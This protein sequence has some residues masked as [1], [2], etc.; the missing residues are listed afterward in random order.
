MVVIPPLEMARPGPVVGLI[1]GQ[2]HPLNVE[3]AERRGGGQKDVKPLP[4]RFIRTSAGFRSHHGKIGRRGF[5]SFEIRPHQGRQFF[6]SRQGKLLIMVDFFIRQFSPSDNPNFLT[7]ES[8]NHL[9]TP[10][11][12][13][14]KPAVINFIIPCWGDSR[15]AL[16]NIPDF[17]SVLSPLTLRRN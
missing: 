17:R 3:E 2:L 4:I 5:L 1:R 12:I 16:T 6:S 10:V 11:G 7:G 13:P 14:S 15:I 9:R 8:K